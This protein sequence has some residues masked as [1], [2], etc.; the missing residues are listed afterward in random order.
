MSFPVILGHGLSL[1]E[2]DLIDLWLT[3]QGEFITPRK[4]LPVHLTS[5][6]VF[7]EEGGVAEISQILEWGKPLLV[8]VGSGQS[9]RDLDRLFSL[10]V[11]AL[12]R[13]PAPDEPL[14]FPDL[15][16]RA[17]RGNVFALV[18]DE[19]FRRS[20]RQILRF[21][22]FDIRLDFPSSRELVA[23]LESC[24]DGTE[25]SQPRLIIV[26]LD[27]RRMDISAFFYSLRKMFGAR[28]G[29]AEKMPV[30]LTKDFSRPGLD[31]ADLATRVRP[32]IRRVFH[33]REALCAVLEA[34]LF[35]D[36]NAVGK[37]EMTETFNYRSLHTLL[38]D[39]PGTRGSRPPSQ[40]LELINSRAK[41]L[42]KILPFILHYDYL[43]SLS[44]P[45][46]TVFA[47]QP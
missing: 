35:H 34:Y 9:L 13:L 18:A 41:R 3:G 20:L 33:P 29:L 28:P 44:V 17:N 40:T 19:S 14:I 11:S 47:S 1:P 12:W 6:R 36:E 22:G 2:K 38:H 27:D 8:I 10:G 46:G 21:A 7:F 32:Y 37:S 5:E 23:N 25:I 45:E 31:I 4:V 39:T 26:D 42:R 16:T 30:L 15:K 43:L 24:I